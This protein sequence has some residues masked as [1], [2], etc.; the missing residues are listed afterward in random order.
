M[1]ILLIFLCQCECNTSSNVLLMSASSH[2]RFENHLELFTHQ[3]AAGA[4]KRWTSG[5]V[6]E[7]TIQFNSNQ[8]NSSDGSEGHA[9]PR[10]V[11]WGQL[12][13]MRIV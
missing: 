7:M 9:N 5:G 4:N 8:F 3:V 13:M 11:V 2:V 10:L 12:F 1:R 6:H